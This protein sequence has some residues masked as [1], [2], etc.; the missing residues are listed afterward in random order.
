MASRTTNY[1]EIQR[2]EIEALRSIYMEDFEEQEA[3]TGAW[4]KAMDSSFKINLRALLGGEEKVALTLSVSLP[5]TYPKSL[6]RLQ[7][8][9]DEDLRPEAREQAKDVVNTKPRTL[10]GSEMVFELA[11]SLQEIL[12][13]TITMSSQ[14][15]PTLVSSF[16]NPYYLLQARLGSEIL[17]H[18][19][20]YVSICIITNINRRRGPLTWKNLTGRGASRS[21]VC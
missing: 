6:P 14:D 8:Q 1:S 5:P 20:L 21:R 16:S 12:D 10:L 9:F 3:K 19:F 2:D 11:T 18:N 15:V 17:F 7:L 4:K 13:N